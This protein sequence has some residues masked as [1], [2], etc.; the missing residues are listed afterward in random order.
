M[1]AQTTDE[2]AAVF[3]TEVD[4]P[5]QATCGDED[6]LWSDASVYR[7]MTEAADAVARAVQ[8]NKKALVLPYLAGAEFVA[9]PKNVQHLMTVRIAGNGAS[10]KPMTA[11]EAFDRLYADAVAVGEPRCYFWEIDQRKLILWPRPADA[12]SLAVFAETRLGYPLESGLPLPFSDPPEQRLMLTYMKARAYEQQDAET[13]DLNRAKEFQDQ[14][15]S[16]SKNREVENRK[17]TRPVG[18]VQMDW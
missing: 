17:F 1:L 4:D 3:R 5:L 12:G 6:C 10:V 18:T 7:F 16:A 13:L 15:D 14:F 8:R 11:E 2:L 9:V